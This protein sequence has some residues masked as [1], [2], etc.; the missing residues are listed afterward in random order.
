ME[1]ASAT[2][3]ANE[4]GKAP[5]QRDGVGKVFEAHSR[6]NHRNP[7]ASYAKAEAFR[8]EEQQPGRGSTH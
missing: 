3:A 7:G 1:E 4:G 6:V 2:Q 5:R 8:R